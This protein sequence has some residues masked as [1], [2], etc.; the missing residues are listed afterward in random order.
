[1]TKT[2]TILG[3]S[4]AAVFAVSMLGSVYASGHL[5]G[6]D[7]S[8]ENKGKSQSVHIDLAAPIPELPAGNFGWALPTTDKNGDPK[9]FL[10]IA[11]HPDAVDSNVQPPDEVMHTHFL[12]AGDTDDCTSGTTP[13]FASKNHVG[14]LSI[15]EDRL[16]I[17]V[18]NIPRGS[19]GDLTG[20]GFG[21]TLSFEDLNL[22]E[23]ESLCINPVP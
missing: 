21:F 16:S 1:M 17:W 20:T 3:L 6:F 5:T 19:A 7:I 23:I 10:V 12:T 15:S 11:S 9:G 22:D 13:T 4:L 2:K 18:T 8:V 14:K